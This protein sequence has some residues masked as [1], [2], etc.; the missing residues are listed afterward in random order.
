VALQNDS[1][2]TQVG[3]SREIRIEMRPKPQKKC[4]TRMHGRARQ[5]I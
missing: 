1:V 5:P 2:K 4:H 3:H